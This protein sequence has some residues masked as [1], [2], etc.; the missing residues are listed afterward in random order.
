MMY[1]HIGG[2]VIVPLSEVVG[3][4]RA[5]SKQGEAKSFIL[6]RDNTMYLSSI[7]RRHAAQAMEKW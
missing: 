1:L 3:V 7:F 6:M 5:E 4:F 2:E